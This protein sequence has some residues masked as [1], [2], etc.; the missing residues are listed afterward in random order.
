[1]CRKNGCYCRNTSLYNINYCETD[2]LIYEPNYSAFLS[3]DEPAFHYNH[4]MTSGLNYITHFI[5]KFLNQK[6][7][8]TF[9]KVTSTSLIFVLTLNVLLNPRIL[10]YFMFAKTK[11]IKVFVNY[12]KTTFKWSPLGQNNQTPI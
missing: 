3:H 11:I 12:I 7:Q 5:H 6:L 10:I 9:Y 8:I 1:M 4:Q 2:R